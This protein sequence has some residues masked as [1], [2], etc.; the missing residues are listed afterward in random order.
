LGLYEG[1]PS[2]DPIAIV[3][4]SNRLHVGN[5]SFPCQWETLRDLPF[6]LPINAS[7]NEILS[8]R[9]LYTE[10][11]LSRA[12]LIADLRGAE[13]LRDK[14]I[15]AAAKALSPLEITKLD[16]LEYHSLRLKQQYLNSGSGAEKPG[17]TGEGVNP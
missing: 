2:G 15:A 16:L 12:G 14:A 6:T 17:S 3:C 5:Y 7:I 1:L 11:E 4:E 9:L 10:A 13:I 8:C